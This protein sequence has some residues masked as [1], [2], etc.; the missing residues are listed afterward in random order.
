MKTIWLWKDF[1]SHWGFSRKD[2]GIDLLG[3]TYL[4]NLPNPEDVIINKLLV[5][6]FGVNSAHTLL[7]TYRIKAT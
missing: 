5:D 6:S 1:P 4:G 2:A 7:S 3:K